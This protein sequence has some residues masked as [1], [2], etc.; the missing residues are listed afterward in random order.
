M[1]TDESILQMSTDESILQMST[2]ESI[3]QMS[4]DGLVAST[5]YTFIIHVLV[6]HFLCETFMYLHI[7]GLCTVAFVTLMWAISTQK[8]VLYTMYYVCVLV[9]ILSEMLHFPLWS[10]HYFFPNK[11]VVVQPCPRDN[12]Y[13][14][15]TLFYRYSY[16]IQVTSFFSR[17]PQF[18]YSFSS[19]KALQWSI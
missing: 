15:N 2:D 13:K 17:H 10:N 4:T 16:H 14:Y 1:S 11:Q 3:L 12:I 5:M 8:H 18:Y 9:I 6:F 19:Y 7:L